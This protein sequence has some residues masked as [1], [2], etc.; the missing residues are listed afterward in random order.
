MQDKINILIEL[1]EAGADI[2]TAADNKN[3][4]AVPEGYFNDL[5]KD[6]LT[7]LFIKSLPN[8]IPYNIP[9]N[10]FENFPEI[11]LE[12]L[13]IENGIDTTQKKLYNIPEGY[14]DNLA[15]NILKKIK[16]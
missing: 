2:L 10:Y 15:D 11:L 7:N 14:F 16:N 4:F 6:I 12:K 3:Y 5:S 9:A 13:R 8:K 1:K